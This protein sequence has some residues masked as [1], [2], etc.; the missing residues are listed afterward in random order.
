M[1]FKKELIEAG[2]K[3][4]NSGLTIE[5]WGNISIRDPKTNYV[6]MTPSAM[7]YDSITEDDII[8]CTVEGQ[9]IEGKR[10]PTIEKD[11]HLTIFKNR[12]EVNAIV[13]THPM[14][15][16]IY[17]CQG[18]DIR[19]ITDEAAQ[20]LGDVCRCAKYGLP[21]TKELS[22]NCSQA[23]GKKANSCLL[24]SHGAVG[25]GCDL[26]S[27]FRVCKVLEVTAQINYMIEA[28]NNTP[29]YISDEN[30]EAMKS[31]VKNCYGQDK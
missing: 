20:A 21:G 23:L 26:Q 22:E 29:I 12:G 11:L 24:Q 4:Y 25:V 10:K 16:M 1:N 8:V 3:M 14:Y 17:A 5:T 6:Y 13:H 2:L 15:S 19:L 9:I 7:S 18:R 30:I 27:A 28:T 31:F